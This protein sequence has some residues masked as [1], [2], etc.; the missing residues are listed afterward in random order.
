M[1][2][3]SAAGKTKSKTQTD[4]PAASLAGKP[5]AL[6]DTRAIYCGDCLK[7]VIYEAFW[8]ALSGDSC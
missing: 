5:P 4:A 8:I 2:K 1:G 6:L 7:D 3:K